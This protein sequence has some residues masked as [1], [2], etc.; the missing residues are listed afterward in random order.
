MKQ[1][2]TI[3]V[4]GIEKI[5][6][7]QLLEIFNIF[8][9]GSNKLLNKSPET[10]VEINFSAG[11]STTF[12]IP[13]FKA[14]FSNK[15][16]FESFTFMC[17]YEWGSCKFF[18]LSKNLIPT[19]KG[20]YSYHISVDC[21]DKTRVETQDFLEM[22]SAEIAEVISPTIV[23]IPKNLKNKNNENNANIKN[24][25]NNTQKKTKSKTKLAWEII[26]SIIS[27]LASIVTII[28]A[29]KSCS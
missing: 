23:S 22:I 11:N 7:A 29:F 19:E 20:A 12:S 28:T 14:N 21:N 5:S 3:F 8:E 1:N 15:D 10:N 2:T 17:Y 9:K 27:V 25:E 6:K 26:G 24:V 13:E 4:D 16:L 18:H